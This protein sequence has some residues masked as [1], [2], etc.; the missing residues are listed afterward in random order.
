MKERVPRWVKSL[1]LKAGWAD[2]LASFSY[3]HKV[4]R[5]V[6]HLQRPF[7]CWS[8]FAPAEHLLQLGIVE[9]LGKLDM[10]G[11]IA[12]DEIAAPDGHNLGIAGN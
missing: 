10:Q 7:R 4:G 1:L 8:S 9:F 6:A 11:I 3:D 12:A 2:C 5:I